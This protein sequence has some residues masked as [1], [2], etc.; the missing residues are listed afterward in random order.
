MER[1]LHPPAL[2]D[3][4]LAPRPRLREQ[5]PKGQEHT[6]AADLCAAG[7]GGKGTPRCRQAMAYS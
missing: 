1:S 6:W 4:R 7:M 5:L 2:I 3:R